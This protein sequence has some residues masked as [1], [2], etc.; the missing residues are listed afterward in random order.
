M[1][2]CILYVMKEGTTLLYAIGICVPHKDCVLIFVRRTDGLIVLQISGSLREPR[3]S[4][5]ECLV[6]DHQPVDL[7]SP[8]GG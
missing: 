4:P 8:P 5:G 7:P 3:D 6:E 1:H 2:W